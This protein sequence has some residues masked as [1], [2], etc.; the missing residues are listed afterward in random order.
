MKLSK[1]TFLYSI[2]ISAALVGLIIVYFVTMLPSLYV[3]YMKKKNLETVMEMEK[4]YMENRS[5][6]GIEVQNPTGSA[7]FEIPFTGDEIYMAGKGFKFTFK[8]RNEDVKKVLGQI[9]TVLSD[10]ENANEDDIDWEL[11]FENI[12]ADMVF[13]SDAPV[14][15]RAEVE[16]DAAMMQDGT[17]K[18]HVEK[19]GLI[20]FETEVFDKL[21]RYTSY[22]AIG[23]TDNA[24]IVTFLPVMTPQMK[25]IKPIVLGSIPMMAVVLFLIVLI[26]SEIFS[27]KIVNPV[28]RLAN[29]AEEVK[30]A[31]NMEITPLIVKEK[32][33]I[34]DLGRTLNELYKKLKENY[35]KLEEENKRQEVFLR[36]SSHQ[37]KTPIA[38]AMLLVDGMTQEV[39][40][41]KDTKAYLPQVKEQLKSMQKVVD[42]ILYLNHCGEDIQCIS[43]DIEGVL[44]EIL[45]AYRVQIEEKRLCCFQIGEGK[46]VQSDEELLK[47]LLDNL[48]SNAVSH[49]EEDGEIKVE[50]VGTVLK[51]YNRKA[52][53][54]EELLP[55]ICEPF[56]SSTDKR[57][58]G[59]G[60][61]V[62]SYYCNVL[63][64]QFQIENVK[65][66]VMATL[67]FS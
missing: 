15:I 10:I 24:V 41:Y 63:G 28:I 64:I 55:H 52:H 36:A 16:E 23:K 8:I 43:V 59:L 61:Y 56:V 62:V 57:G 33:E 35:K 22:I 12:K 2:V 3:D 50:L 31:E 27:K 47:K 13:K 42:D 4:G 49:T 58:R 37:L 45:Q 46:V 40:K 44:E 6:K 54:D 25:E 51:I 65:D 38:A 9:R 26:C 60:L 11:L 5:Y 14:D 48:I 18:V 19:D 32:D 34:G 20:V 21:N 17:V 66:G 29:Y 1:K 7:T 67:T 30:M 39:G 53:I